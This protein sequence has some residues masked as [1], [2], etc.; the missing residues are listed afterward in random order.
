MANPN[1]IDSGRIQPSLV[2]ILKQGLDLSRTVVSKALGTHKAAPGA[3][4]EA[5]QF[6]SRNSDGELIPCTGLNCVGMAKWNKTTQ[7]TGLAKEEAIVLT[8]TAAIALKHPLVSGVLVTTVSGTALTVTTDYT[9]NATNGTVTRVGSGAIAD[10]D[11]VLVTYR[12]TVQ[13][14]DLEFSGRN[15][16][17][18]LDDAALQQG[19]MTMLQ[20]VGTIFTANYDQQRQY[21]INQDLYC[22]ANGR[23]TNVSSGG[24]NRVGKVSQLPTADDPYLGF[25]MIVPVAQ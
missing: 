1:G 24:G 17:N 18:L 14:A 4:F 12:Y 7:F 9:V 16:F 22:D 2:P 10:G 13:A 5:G 8:G 11:T 6:L 15:F 23:P 3:L 20:G 21:T 19:R 25:E